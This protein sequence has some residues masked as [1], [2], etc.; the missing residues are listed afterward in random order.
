MLFPHFPICLSF[1]HSAIKPAIRLP[2]FSPSPPADRHP[3]Y[4]H[5]YNHIICD[6]YFLLQFHLHFIGIL[7]TF[8]RLCYDRIIMFLKGFVTLRISF[9]A[10]LQNLLGSAILAFGLYHVHSFSGVTE[11]GILGFTL[12]LHHWFHISPAVSS[13]VLNFISYAVAAK[14]F[15]RTFI[16]YSLVAGGGFS[17]FYAI[18]EQFPPLWPQLASMPLLAAI[19]GALFVGIGIG[20]SLRA[21]GAPG[22]D[23]ALAMTLSKLTGSSIERMY[24][25][26]DLVVL[27]LSISYIPL[28]KLLC[29]LITVVLSGQIIGLIQR[30]PSKKH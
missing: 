23:D 26:S 20:I 12:L 22:G 27:A 28:D 3:L 24:L 17:A 10:C 11:G 7:D 16:I 8:A 4:F 1:Y 19:V 13:F 6:F 5:V 18:F 29:S 21:G 2:S 15:G 25:I 30:I 14:M 9:R